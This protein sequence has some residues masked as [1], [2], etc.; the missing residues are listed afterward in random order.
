MTL[1]REELQLLNEKYCGHVTAAFE[2]DRQRLYSGEPLAYI[3]GWQPF[4]GLRIYLDTHPL[5]P[6]PETEWWTEQLLSII[7]ASRITFLDLCAGSGAIGCAALARFPAAEVYFGEI[8][9]AHEQ[10]ITKNIQM[11][12]LDITRAHV[13][14]GDLFAPFGDNKFDVV[15]I[16]PPYIPLG[17]PLPQGVQ[18]F[19]PPVALFAGIDGLDVLKRI[20][21]KLRKHLSPSGRAWIECDTMFIEQSAKLFT[22]QGFE[23]SIRTDQYAVP[24]ILVVS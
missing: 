4:V 21:L 13:R 18:A 19:E 5:I 2:L 9:Q 15:A 6:R 14:I 11:N 7:K 1:T 17:R 23:V 3:I 12:G 10:T 22:T 16:N 24:R 8:D 20:A